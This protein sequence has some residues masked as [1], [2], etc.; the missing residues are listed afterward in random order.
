MLN[1]TLL[2]LFT[3]TAF[4]AQAWII[5]SGD[6]DTWLLNLKAK[7]SV[8]TEMNKYF[9]ENDPQTDATP[10]IKSFIP[11]VH[12]ALVAEAQN[13]IPQLVDQ[14][15][16]QSMT[17]ISYP[18]AIT[19]QYG[20]KSKINF[21]KE[22]LKIQSYNCLGKLN[23]HKVFETLMSAEF[24]KEAVD[25][26]KEVTVDQ[27][28]N[29]ICQR[30][31]MFPLGT[32]NFCFTQN[33]L[34]NDNQYII[35]SYNEEN[36]DSPSI[37]AYFRE[38]ITVITQLENSEVSIYNLALGRGPDLPFH[39]IVEKIVSRQQNKIFNALTKEAQ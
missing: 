11:A 19:H 1:K 16:C 36:N 9:E 15:Q 10:Y 13:S 29:Q 5:Q 21:E 37:V 18:K 4:N 7:P 3:L 32:T 27:K 30:I 34:L 28:T 12:Q 26:M 23:V 22:I 39:S 24:Q 33:I 17:K 20:F 6:A 31:S 25:G 8:Y 14:S 2:A 38:A 35:H